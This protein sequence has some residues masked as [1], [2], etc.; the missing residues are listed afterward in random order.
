MS[1]YS[2]DDDDDEEEEE[3]EDNDKDRETDENNDTERPQRTKSMEQQLVALKHDDDPER[4][5][6]LGTDADAF[7]DD[8]ARIAGDGTGEG[9]FADA[10][11]EAFGAGGAGTAAEAFSRGV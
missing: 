5:E 4:S 1:E 6:L 7:E 9:G 2:S 3:E 10:F 11:T 8:G